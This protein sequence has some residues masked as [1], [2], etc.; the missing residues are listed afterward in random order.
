MRRLS[1]GLTALTALA[2]GTAAARPAQWLWNLPEGVEPP[3]AP[4]DNPMNAAKV[5]LGR[6][7]FYDADLSV[8]GTM[9]C[10]TCHEQKRAF[11]DGNRTRPGVH[12]DPGRRNVPGL[13]NVG[14]L[15][16]LTWADPRLST[17]EVQV[18]VPIFGETPVEMGMKGKE[19]ELL[20]RLSRDKCYIRMFRNAFPERRGTIDMPAVS[21]ALAAFQRTLLSHASLYDRYRRGEESAFPAAARRG[22]ALFGAHCA[23][24]HSGGNF[25]DQQFHAIEGK[26]TSSDMGLAEITGLPEDHGRFRTPSLRNVALTG[27]Y[28][29]DG[30][31]A[32]LPE[33][34]AR[35]AFMVPLAGTLTPAQRDDL[36][37]FLDTLTDREFVENPK[38]AYP[39]TACGKPL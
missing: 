12:G 6:R 2:L 39:E 31:A 37:A 32:S 17:L 35:H 23:S 13:A 29:H 15:S 16:P 4:A 34:I 18:A 24:C 25:T 33:A 7:L 20:R 19:Q 22:E 38:F 27:P 28:L 26:G 21:K 36:L 8:D 3:P 30:S 9:S 11:A 1:I 14:Y 5:E 10:A